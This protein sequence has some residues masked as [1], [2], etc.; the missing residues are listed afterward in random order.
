MTL[1][2]VGTAIAMIATEGQ[3][4]DSP[5]TG[6]SQEDTTVQSQDAEEANIKIAESLEPLLSK[7][8]PWK[9]LTQRS[10]RKN[11]D[12]IL[13]SLVRNI[14]KEEGLSLAELDNPMALD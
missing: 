2:P 11:L 12:W 6:S 14:A 3:V 4:A 10:W 8:L 5:M 13:L 1:S 9:W 7:R